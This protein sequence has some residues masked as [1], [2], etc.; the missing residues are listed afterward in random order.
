[1][2]CNFSTG[3]LPRRVK[4]RKGLLAALPSSHKLWRESIVQ[5]PSPH[6][7]KI[8]FLVDIKHSHLGAGGL[9]RKQVLVSQ[10]QVWA[11]QKSLG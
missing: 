10:V 7:G 9:K 11:K 4:S 3:Q 5:I 1:M 8:I 6:T 2:L